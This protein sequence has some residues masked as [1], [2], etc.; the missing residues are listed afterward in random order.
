MILS[1]LF[2]LIFLAAGVFVSEWIFASHA[3]GRRIWLGLV[4]G[5][6]LWTWL[7]SLISF[8]I[9]FT[10][11]SNLIAMAIAAA[12]L[13]A[14]II[15]NRKRI[16]RAAH[17]PS[18][19]WRNLILL[20]PIAAVGI[21]LFSTHVLLT[22]NGDYYVG[23]TT[24]GDLA[25]HLGFIT[26][27]ARQGVFPP[28][29][30]IFPGHSVN[31]PFLCETSSASLLTLGCDL[32]SSY[33]I[34]CILAFLLVLTG[35][36]FFF[37]QWLKKRNTALFATF[38]FFIGGGFG[39]AYFLDLANGGSNLLSAVVPD[40][41]GSTAMQ[42]LMDGYYHTPTNIPAIGLRWVNPIVDMLIPQRATLFG[43]MLLFPCLYLLYG[44]MFENKSK[45]ILPLA[46]LAGGMPLIHTHSFLA[47]GVISAVYCVMDLARKFDK[48]RLLRWA[49]YGAIAIVLAMLQL[50]PFA[51]QQA[52]ESGLV[53]LHFNW[54]NETDSYL[55]FYL[56]NFGS[57]A[58]LT[59]LA[60]LC[61]SKRDRSVAAGPL[62]LWLIAECVIFQPNVYD[63][64]KL[65]F[66][67]FA[68]ACGLSAR[69]VCSADRRLLMRRGRLRL[70]SDDRADSLATALSA[71]VPFVFIV[72]GMLTCKSGAPAMRMTTAGT[73]LVFIG[74]ALFTEISHA[75]GLLRQG[76][77]RSS[78]SVLIN[79]ALCASAG[80]MLT[81]AI[82]NQYRQTVLSLP[83][84]LAMT[85]MCQLFGVL[86]L[87]MIR[88]YR[89]STSPIASGAWAMT[90][91]RLA[92]Y[93][94]CLS[95]FLSGVM[96]ILRET[97]SR[98]QVFTKAQI[99][100][101][102][103]VEDSTEPDSVFLTDYSWH[104][105]PISV[106]TGRNIVCGPGL[107]LYYHGIDTTQ[108]QQDVTSMLENPSESA[109]LFDKYQVSYVYLGTSERANY[110]IDDA[111]FSEHAE[112]IYDMDAIQIYR[113]LD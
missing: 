42:Y 69:L 77:P 37:E 29:Y 106:L 31:Y 67:C 15:L 19:T 51:F 25:M 103:F 82:F 57:I 73:C 59:P 1:V 90:A 22:V 97:K 70:V 39:F 18:G 26:S 12:I 111:Y 89:H 35:V 64:N 50:I 48:V 34:P 10:L 63:N 92:L 105:N 3:F 58:L 21:Y 13:I 30:S 102:A 107:Y 96:T 65:L 7:P 109:A 74:F 9:G 79:A 43:W 32:R 78:I 14:S 87:C 113:L 11:V 33:L 60:F 72:Y 52:S 47:L 110:E 68:F 38:L 66:V 104:L 6:F 4:I 41:S 8:L 91:R 61:L 5:L 76:K 98:Y 36:Y 56:K 99:A 54:G 44:W 71:A 17:I 86:L 40:M 27:I 88:Q 23:Q 100:S 20:L 93:I 95:L 80:I 53:Q 46:I 75:I 49:E 108:R 81:V 2:I 112:L 101:A 16:F 45:N 28:D 84:P 94:L 55:W 83:Y 62:V 24:Y 85:L